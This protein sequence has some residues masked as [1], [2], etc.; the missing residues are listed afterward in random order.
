MEQTFFSVKELLI[1]LHTWQF[2]LYLL[3]ERPKKYLWTFLHIEIRV[4]KLEHGHTFP[5]ATLEGIKIWCK[6]CWTMQL[7]K[8]WSLWSSS[9]F[10]WLTSLPLHLQLFLFCHLYPYILTYTFFFL[11]KR[12]KNTSFPQLLSAISER[13]IRWRMRAWYCT[14]FPVLCLFYSFLFSA[15]MHMHKGEVKPGQIS[16]HHVLGYGTTRGLSPFHRHTEI[17]EKEKSHKG[18]WFI[19]LLTCFPSLLAPFL[20]RGPRL[21][22]TDLFF[23]EVTF[24]S[25]WN[26]NST[27]VTSLHRGR[28]PAK[29]LKL[30]G[31]GGKEIVIYP[32]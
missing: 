30:R 20:T 22:R 28:S 9:C 32:M 19:F 31:K 1:K 5:L 24:W 25:V 26:S 18:L 3:G 11:C 7:Q 2:Y 21:S 27:P 13:Q 16:C 12:K 17:S 14:T 4:G 6:G 29:L 15:P 23:Y 10:H 8:E